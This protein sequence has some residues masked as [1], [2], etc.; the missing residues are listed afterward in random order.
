MLQQ[1]LCCFVSYTVPKIKAPHTALSS[2]TTTTAAAA[3]LQADV[4]LLPKLQPAPGNHDSGD[5]F[6]AALLVADPSLFS[7]L[8]HHHQHQQ[9]QQKEQQQLN[10]RR[11]R[12]AFLR[13]LLV[14]S[15]KQPG[16]AH[17]PQHRTAASE[18]QQQ[19]QQG[20]TG[21]AGFNSPLVLLL[22]RVAVW[23]LYH[24]AYAAPAHIAWLG[25]DC[26]LLFRLMPPQLQLACMTDIL[27]VLSCPVFHTDK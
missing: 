25:R 6:E 22:R 3:A 18:Q 26:E 17:L 1:Q 21:L 11:C 15:C 4:D 13:A 8:N 27:L 9:Q 10:R 19:Q 24:V 16:F 23:W 5:H 20:D 7:N 2:T 14:S 12:S